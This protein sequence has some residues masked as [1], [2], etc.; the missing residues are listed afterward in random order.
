MELNNAFGLPSQLSNGL[1]CYPISLMEYDEFSYLARKFIILDINSIDNKLLQEFQ[2]AQKER[3]IPRNQKYE[4]IDCDHL[5]D[6]I[7]K[8]IVKS[9]NDLQLKSNIDDFITNLPEDKLNSLKEHDNS[10]G[11]II[12]Y[13]NSILVTDIKN[14]FIRFLELIFRKKVEFLNFKFFVSDGDKILGNIN[15]DNFYEFRSMV[16]KQNV[17][18]EPEVMPGYLEQ[19]YYDLDKK[20]NESSEGDLESI[21]FLVQRK[22]NKNVEDMTYYQLIANLR[23]I[24]KE[25]EFDKVLR[26]F[27]C[28]MASEKTKLPDITANLGMNKN[29]ESAFRK[30]K[31]EEWESRLKKV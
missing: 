4:H 20:A 17:L 27:S 23:S 15:K 26:S 9:E 14:E 8:L 28:G 16:M 2:K 19:Y 24:L 18:F 7:I 29:P 3:K 10:V 5:Y 12:E 11:K 25:K 30:M 13:S 1:L 22:T 31:N 6:W 21:V